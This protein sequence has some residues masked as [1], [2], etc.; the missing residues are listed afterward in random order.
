MTL[1]SLTIAGLALRSV[2]TELVAGAGQTLALSAGDIAARLDSLLAERHGDAQVL[3][4][5]PAFRGANRAEM[6][7]LLSAFEEA[8]PVYRW[9]GVLDKE[10]RVVAATIPAT[11]GHDLSAR[12]GFQ[13]ARAGRQIHAQDAV[14]VE[15]L[16]GETAV[17]FTG[18]LSGPGGEFRGAVMT[19]VEVPVLDDVMA[20]STNALQAQWGTSPRIESQLLNAQGDLLID[21]PLREEGRVNLKQAG[22]PSA[23]L[24]SSAPP[25]YVEERHLRRGAEV[26]TGYA[27]TKGTPEFEGFRWGVLIR[28]DRD[29]ILVP[30]RKTVLRFALLGGVV[31]LPLLCVLAW[32]AVRLRQQFDRASDACAKA[33]SAEA[34][35]RELFEAAHDAI[36]LADQQ[37]NILSWNPAGEKMF[38][39]CREEVKGKPLT[40]LMPERYRE[41]HCRGLE[42]FWSTGGTRVLGRVAEVVGLRRDGSEF[43]LELSLAAWTSQGQGFTCG[44]LRDI[45]ERKQAEAKLAEAAER[46]AAQNQELMQV[47]DAALEAARVKSEFLATMSHEIRTPM[48]ACSGSPVTT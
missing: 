4:R 11:V 16:D 1:G 44:M 25:G 41:A 42:R 8:Y 12:P 32:S 39:Y 9:L 17:I 18:R 31:L 46:L 34:K 33:E 38:G 22:V 2:E 27:T 13:A 19:M 14:R 30:I 6:T 10:G 20:H 48:S 28:I 15:E 45:T 23:V 26:V 35:S 37:G 21:S 3:V 36:V 43:P 24:V 29:D 40:I 5:M 7:Q 47:R